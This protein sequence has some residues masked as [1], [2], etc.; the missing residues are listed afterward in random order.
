[1]TTK[2][3]TLKT[4]FLT[5]LLVL[6][7]LGITLWV[8]SLIIGTMDQT[9]LLLPEAWQPRQHLPG[10]GAVLTLAFIFVVGLFTQNF[11][12]QKLVSWWNALVRRIPLVG[13]LYSSVQQVSDTLLSSNGNAFRKALLIEYPRK[14]SWT[15][16]FLTGIPGGDVANHLQE[17]HVSVYVPTTP[18]PTS[19]FFLMV[20]KREAIELDMT[21]DAAL[22]Y[23]VSMGVV[24]PAAPARRP[25]DPPM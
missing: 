24:A 20:P 2:K 21:V 22:K 9:L 15:I 8:L 25:I 12:G 19:G 3:A 10:L 4:I 17:D 6:V 5:G 11:I 14:G 23:I 1:M 7:P 16:A 18:N 13:P